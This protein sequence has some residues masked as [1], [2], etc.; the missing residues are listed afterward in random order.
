ME[1]I[2]HGSPVSGVSLEPVFHGSPVSGVA[3]ETWRG[4]VMRAA[5]GPAGISG[6]GWKSEPVVLEERKPTAGGASPPPRLNLNA[7]CSFNPGGGGGACTHHLNRPARR[8]RLTSHSRS[9]EFDAPGIRTSGSERRACSKPFFYF[10]LMLLR[11]SGTGTSPVPRGL[12][13]VHRG[14][15]GRAIRRGVSRR[16]GKF[17]RASGWSGGRSVPDRARGRVRS[18]SGG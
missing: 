9:W 5:A 3:L 1:P 8:R 6:Q 15:S 17:H 10:C 4:R 16:E 2:F 13:P 12:R 11:I 14:W 18:G 7:M